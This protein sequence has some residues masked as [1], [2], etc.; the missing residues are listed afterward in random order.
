MYD[1]EQTLYNIKFSLNN[2]FL[3]VKMSPHVVNLNSSKSDRD[4]F[5]DAAK[6]SLCVRYLTRFHSHLLSF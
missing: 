6:S 5:L 3:P 2:W 1:S 4:L